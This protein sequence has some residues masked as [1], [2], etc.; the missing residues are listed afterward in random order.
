[1]PETAEWYIYR[2]NY[3]CGP[4]MLMLPL[5][6]FIL[7]FLTLLPQDSKKNKRNIL[8]IMSILLIVMQIYEIWLWVAPYGL[9][10]DAAGE[11]VR[12]G[13]PPS[14]PWM[15]FA[16]TLGFFGLFMVVVARSLAQHSL[17][18]LNDPYLAESVPHSQD[19]LIYPN[20][21]PDTAA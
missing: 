7:P 5:L 20:G 14:L 21:K 8:V 3:G 1:M 19:H 15:E 11:V 6:K 16:I 9:S 10:L 18:P 4:I 2:V 13:I 12:G 17:V